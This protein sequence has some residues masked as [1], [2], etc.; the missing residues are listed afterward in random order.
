MR[1]MACL[2]LFRARWEPASLPSI[3]MYGSCGLPHQRLLAL[4]WRSCLCHDT[5]GPI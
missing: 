4:P 1:G 3:R 2:L 5:N